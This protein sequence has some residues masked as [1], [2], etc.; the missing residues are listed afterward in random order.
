MTCSSFGQYFNQNLEAIGLPPLDNAYTSAA[1]VYADAAAIEALVAKYGTRVTV[2]EMVKAGILGERLLPI[3]AILVSFA[4]GY[5]IGSALV[6]TVKVTR[7]NRSRNVDITGYGGLKDYAE[8][9]QA[10]A[11]TTQKAVTIARANGIHNE[12]ILN[13]LRTYP[14]IYNEAAPSRKALASI[15]QAQSPQVHA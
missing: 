8:R 12:E 13:I 5:M 1:A 15:A 3:G 14:R 10:Q 11:L 7:C 9:V 2:Y 4:A 6:A